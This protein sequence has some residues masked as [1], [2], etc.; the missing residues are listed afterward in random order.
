MNV[1]IIDDDIEFAKYFEKLFYNFFSKRFE[2]ITLKIITDNFSYLV[3][4]DIDI[5]FID[6]DLKSKNGI[7]IAS[8]IKKISE[9]TIIIFVSSKEELVFKALSVGPFHFIRKS[10]IDEDSII[11]F[12]NLFNYLERN[13][14]KLLLNING[15]KTMIQLLEIE[16]ILAIGKDL[17]IIGN[18]FEFSLKSS[19]K[20][21]LDQVYNV[22]YYNLIQI[23]RNIVIN[24]CYIENI[25]KT[26]LTL[27]NGIEYN[28]GKVYYNNVIEKYE[29]FLLR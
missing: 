14:K 20:S 4:T 12:N 3:H 26:K 2:N 27:K 28:I 29:E 7:N 25:E 18:N 1:L 22:K 23:N 21:F 6:I 8:Y 11:V 24:M 16:Y 19:I 10:H 5:C 9:K 15:R 13:Q 17:V